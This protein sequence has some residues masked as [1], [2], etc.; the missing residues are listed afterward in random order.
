MTLQL[1]FHELMH[2]LLLFSYSVDELVEGAGPGF[3]EQEET[4]NSGR[5]LENLSHRRR[6][7][8]AASHQGA[9]VWGSSLCV[10][11]GGWRVWGS[12]LCEGTH[13]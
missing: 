5:R 1:Q 8:P 2:D 10:E 11:G 7:R 6:Q 4:Q 9:P 3:V 12:G 13:A